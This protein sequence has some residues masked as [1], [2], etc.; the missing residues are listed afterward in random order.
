MSSRSGG[1]RQSPQAQHQAFLKAQAQAARQA[2]QQRKAHEREQKLQAEQQLVASA[3]AK[4]RAVERRVEDLGGLLRHSLRS[5]V[6]L[7][8]AKRKKR[9]E[10]PPLDLGPHATP[11]P[12]PQWT[13]FEPQPPGMLG[14]VFGGQRRHE[15]ARREADEA[16]VR[17][18]SDHA[19]EEN[20]RQETVKEARRLHERR[21]ETAK[22]AAEAHN[23]Q[24]DASI[25]ALQ[26]GERRATSE[27]FEELLKVSV[28]PQGFP[29]RRRAGYVPESKLLAVEWELP[30]VS[31]V[32][33]E[34][35]FR[36]V[37]TRKAIESSS[38]PMDK[39]RSIY[40]QLVAQVA[41]RTMREVF[42][43]DTGTLVDTV[44][45][46]GVV[47]AIDPATG[48]RIRP[49]LITLR[50]TREKFAPLVLENVEPVTCIRK[51][52]FAEVS[53]HPEELEPV[54]P[55]LE[56]NM[57]D[58]RIIEAVD[59]ISD[60]DVRPNLL[61]LEPKQFE[62]FIQNLFT[63]MGFDTKQFQASGDGGVDCVAF[64]P[65]PVFGGKFVIQAKLY[66]KTVPPTAV[67]D[68]YGTM[69]H[70]G[71]TKGILITTSGYG[72]SAYEFANGKPIQ[73]IDASGL[74]FLCQQQGIDARIVPTA[75]GRG[76]R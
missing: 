50:A 57:A 27:Y 28:Y 45:F 76:R 7:D 17:A 43:N 37:K 63:R 70:E 18:Q 2:E 48:Q 35:R 13:D 4:T 69:Q 6:R 60:M 68:L 5:P 74:L 23:A 40:Q 61:D 66:Q 24:V 67:R 1:S 75:P 30:A 25:V 3:E 12:A 16:F 54:E 19:A 32:P 10:I 46:N 29:N 73:L 64:D 11:V 53:K 55:V 34:L 20:R 72:P 39:I 26:A 56:F 33:T 52:F 58:P 65:R 62:A 15:A 8:P 22:L 51:H 14:K 47:D 41:I 59:V 49:C 44:V 42:L 36:A 9:P 71:A 31:I 38:R 21:V